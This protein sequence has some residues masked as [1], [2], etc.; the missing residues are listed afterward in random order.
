MFE[1]IY[2]SRVKLLKGLSHLSRA[3]I[4]GVFGVAHGGAPERVLLNPG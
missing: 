2:F 1:I 4:S 3:V